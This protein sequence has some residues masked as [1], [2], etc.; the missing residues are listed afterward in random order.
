MSHPGNIKACIRELDDQAARALLPTYSELLEA[1]RDT[2][3]ELVRL[4]DLHCD[5]YAGKLGMPDL[6]LA[7]KARDLL[8][9]IPT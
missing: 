7:E 8:A 9:R 2:K 5:R 4:H 1:L 3:Q 6:D